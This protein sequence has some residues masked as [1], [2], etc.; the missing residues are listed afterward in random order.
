MN[1]ALKQAINL[2]KQRLTLY[3]QNKKSSLISIQFDVSG[4]DN[5]DAAWVILSNEKACLSVKFNLWQQTFLDEDGC[6]ESTS[7]LPPILVVDIDFMEEC[8]FNF[9]I[10]CEMEAYNS[11]C[12]FYYPIHHKTISVTDKLLNAFGKLIKLKTNSHEYAKAV[13]RFVNLSPQKKGDIW[14]VFFKNPESLV[15]AKWWCHNDIKFAEQQ[16]LE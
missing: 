3:N 2:F 16:F 4:Y 13:K 9:F 6:C 14:S 12:S 15:R 5:G 1:A 10:L 7:H 11:T 8:F